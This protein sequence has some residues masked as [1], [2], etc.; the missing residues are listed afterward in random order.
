M[1]VQ[2]VMRNLSGVVIAQAV[3]SRGAVQEVT[4]VSGPDVFHQSVVNAM[5]LYKCQQ[6]P[7]EMAMTQTFEFKMETFLPSAS[8][9][10]PKR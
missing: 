3:V 1:P 9:S 6:L 4:I 2:A 8:A 10:A 7:A 5:K